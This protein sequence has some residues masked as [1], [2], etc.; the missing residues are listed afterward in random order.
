V[1]KP[2]KGTTRR[3]MACLQR[4]SSGKEVTPHSR[5]PYI[6]LIPIGLGSW[7]PIY[8]GVKA[9][10]PR[11]IAMGLVWTVMAVVALVMSS[12]HGHGNDGIVGA[13]A[14][15]SWVG[16]IAT[17]FSIRPAYERQIGSPVLTAAQ[18]A[19]Q[20]LRDRR[21]A[22]KIVH[23]N[24]ALAREMGIGRPDVQ[25]AT[26]AGLVDVNNA[27]VTA[28]LR[29]PRIDGDLATAIVEGRGKVNGFSSLEDMGTALDLDGDV[30]EALRGAVVFLPRR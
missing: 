20:Q 17:S 18:A 8:A 9:R 19:E 13:L 5:W 23:D 11:W 4:M 10:E 30:V 2:S 12:G 27:S 1:R 28:L 26:D 29:L 6:S 21:E 24:P 7:A 16:G 14:I 15:I 25:G 3:T 22:L